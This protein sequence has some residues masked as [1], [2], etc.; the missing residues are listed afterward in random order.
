MTAAPFREA[1]GRVALVTGASRGLGAA[2]AERLAQAGAKV[3]VSARTLDPDPKCEGSLSETVAR[4]R[5]AGGVA[6]P[7]QS[8]ISSATDRERMVAAVV[9]ELGPIDILVNNAAVTFL[10]PFTE[11]PEKRFRLMFEV[12]VRAPFELA[13]MVVPSMRERGAGWILN[14]TSRAGIHPTGPPWEDFYTSGSIVYGMV[15]AALDR[16]STGLAAELFDDGI[17]VNSLA[18][19]DNVATPGATVHDLVTDYRLEGPEW[20]AEAAL[21]LCTGDPCKLTARVAYSQPLLAELQRRPHN[22]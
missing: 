5:A 14:I 18:P 17:A 8:D 19:W 22:L 10:L 4:I 15:K 16:F 20:M 21:A 1:E 12:Q 11:F 3:A 6:F 9:E 13:Q 7:V 2:I